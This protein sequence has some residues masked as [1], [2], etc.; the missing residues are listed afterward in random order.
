[1]TVVIV[2]IVKMMMEVKVKK[3]VSEEARKVQW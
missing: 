2:K 1:M 3:I